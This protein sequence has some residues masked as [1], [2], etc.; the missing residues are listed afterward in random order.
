M[1]KDIFKKDFNSLGVFIIVLFVV[2]IIL[3]CIIV[4]NIIFNPNDP[5]INSVYA[6]L[7]VGCVSALGIAYSNSYTKKSLSLTTKSINQNTKSLRQNKKLI[8][9]NEKSLKQNSELIKQNENFLFIQLRFHHA[10]DALYDLMNELQLTILIYN[11]LCSIQTEELYFNPR[12]FLMLQY[13]N[14]ISNLDL[15]KYIP[16]KLRSEFQ[17]SFLNRLGG[18]NEESLEYVELLNSYEDLEIN[19]IAKEKIISFFEYSDCINN[20]NRNCC[21]GYFVNHFRLYYSSNISNEEML[22][23]MVKVIDEISHSKPEDL[24]LAEK[25]LIYDV[26]SYSRFV[27]DLNL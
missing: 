23:L 17:Y 24:I 21:S 20:F 16:V 25:N 18:L 3:I 11:E 22:N 7:F 13:V 6:S 8:K 5:V 26:K 27:K 4:F 12:G 19:N 10:E 1:L 2:I 9:L 14:L 15:L